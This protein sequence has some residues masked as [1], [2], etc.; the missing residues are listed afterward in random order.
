M[1]YDIH[2]AH[3]GIHNGTTP[4]YTGCPGETAGQDNE[5]RRLDVTHEL[6]AE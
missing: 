2:N 4:G 1:H 6:D 3:Y 5:R